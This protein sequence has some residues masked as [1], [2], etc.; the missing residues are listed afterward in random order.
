MSMKEEII[1]R[2]RAEQEFKVKSVL[3]SIKVNDKAFP[4]QR[5]NSP[6]ILSI[7]GACS[8]C[9]SPIYGRKEILPDEDPEVRRTCVCSSQILPL[10]NCGTK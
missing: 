7:I 2:I 1:E 9:D 8:K 6:P 4:L 5:N 3:D 10:P